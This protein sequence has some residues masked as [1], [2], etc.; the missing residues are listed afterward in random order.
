MTSINVA[1]QTRVYPLITAIGAA[2]SLAANL[3]LIPPFGMTGAAVALLSSQTVTTAVTAYFAQR[4]YRIPYEVGRLSKTIGVGATTWL[5]M[6]AATAAS[7]WQTLALRVALV[8]LFPL[9]LLLIRFFEP[10]EL[11]EIRRFVT[12]LG[13]PAAATKPQESQRLSALPMDR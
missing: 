4:A 12:N 3:A 7:P 2:S 5:V 13:R 10:S 1:K 8:A 6:A 9:G 11:F